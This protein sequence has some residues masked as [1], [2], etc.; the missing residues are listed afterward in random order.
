[1]PVITTAA[2]LHDIRGCVKRKTC[3]C[4]QL[5]ICEDVHRR[6]R[7]IEI[8]ENHERF[9]KRLKQIWYDNSNNFK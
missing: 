9:K 4:Y 1:M 3:F 2:L 7:I 5:D 8:M 6:Y